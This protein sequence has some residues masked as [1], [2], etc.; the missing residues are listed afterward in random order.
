MSKVIAKFRCL[1]IKEGLRMTVVTL[2]PVISKS[3]VWPGGSEENAKFWKASPYGE[4]TLNYSDGRAHLFEVGAYYYVD[5]SGDKGEAWA[6]QEVSR[7]PSTLTAKLGL[8]WLHRFDGR[9]TE[10]NLTLTIEN[11]AAWPLFSDHLGEALLVDLRLADGEH[12]TCPYTG[13]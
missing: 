13:Q 3:D 8:P 2:K 11:Q 9:P 7:T 5:F 6:V 1:E 12:P 4:I 10:G